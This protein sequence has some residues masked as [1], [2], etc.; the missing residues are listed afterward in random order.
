MLK[1]LSRLLS[2]HDKPAAATLPPAL[3]S[4]TDLSLDFKL[5]GDHFLDQGKLAEA[6]GFYRQAITADA[7]NAAAHNNLGLVLAD[8]QQ[9]DEAVV[10]FQQALA[11][12]A[13]S[14][15]SLYM[16]GV[17]AQQR[18]GI[19]AAADYFSRALTIQP[20]LPD[21]LDRLGRLL[22]EQVKLSES[23][24]C[25]RQANALHSEQPST[26]SDLLLA[27]QFEGRLSQAE[28]FAEHL[29]YAEHFEAP[30]IGQRQAH[31]NDRSPERRLRVGY[32]SPDFRRHSV[33]LFA[34]PIL[35]AHDKT[36]FEIFGYYCHPDID[37]MTQEI[38][39]S[40]DHF[41]P[42][43]HMSD[44]EL[45]QRIRDDGID[46]LVDLA[47]HTAHNRLTVFSR[48]PAPIQVTYLGY[49][50]T[51]GL[52]AMDYRLAHVD[53]DPPENDRYY[54]EKV[55]RFSE[56]LWWAYR[57]APDLP[58][59]SSLPALTNG[60][61]TFSSNNHVSKISLAMI[62]TWAALLNTVPNARLVMMGVTSEVARNT[63]LA[64]FAGHGIARERI[65]FHGMLPLADYRRILQQ[66]DISLDSYPYNGGTTSCETLWLGL[67]LVTMK[68]QAFVTR[69][70]YA[71]LKEIGLPELV[72][73]T[74][75]DLVRIAA[76]LA[77]DLPRLAQLRSSL[78]TRLAQS[79]LAD[80]HKFTRGLERAYRQMWLQYLAENITPT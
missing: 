4:N 29:R 15:N 60:Y 33:A 6:A 52:A 74:P 48:K 12:D 64:R 22:R 37:P 24:A 35:A 26:W 19:D 32:V 17:I 25:Y 2:A 54:T 55:V 68:G 51:T 1:W 66:A 36:R 67:P 3:A 41:L 46:I 57:P 7:G 78:R 77:G 80:E 71:L 76:E 45:A 8:G 72:A 13:K 16:L 79:T 43:A 56:H 30:L 65:S 63:F 31:T 5:Q 73:D 44:D 59:V 47:G 23:V 50:D 38:A 42:C 14:Y 49:I 75:A 11:I 27:L 70:G 53:T 40:C 39:A 20:E 21:A 69:M 18:G 9:Y 58:D 62:D 10:H 34:L 28:M 61:V